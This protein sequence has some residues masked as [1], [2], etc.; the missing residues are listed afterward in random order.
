MVEVWLGVDCIWCGCEVYVVVV[1]LVG[2]D[3]DVGGVYVWGCDVVL[4]EV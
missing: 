3:M 2:V 1:D 4:C